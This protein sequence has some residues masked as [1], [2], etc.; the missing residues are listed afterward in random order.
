MA[1]VLAS[2]LASVEAVVAAVD[3][4]VAAVDA[5]VSF[6]SVFPHAVNVEIARAAVTAIVII[7]LIIKTSFLFLPI[8]LCLFCFLLTPLI[9]LFLCK[10][11]KQ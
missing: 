4:V 1:S 5:V 7:F 9:L 11:R 6:L 3:A 10:I 2:V 8:L